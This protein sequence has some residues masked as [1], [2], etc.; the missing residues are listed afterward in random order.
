MGDATFGDGDKADRPPPKSPSGTSRPS[1]G[2]TSDKTKGGSADLPAPTQ[3]A[4]KSVDAWGDELFPLSPT[5][6]TH[7]DRWKHAVASALHG[8][9]QFAHD[10][11]GAMELSRGEYLAAIDAAIKPNEQGV[12]TPHK[13][14]QYEPR[15]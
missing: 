6:R 15:S 13:P 12:S 9:P 11:N 2:D 4:D 1:A 14:A 3:D 10:H 7:P 5:G 8:W